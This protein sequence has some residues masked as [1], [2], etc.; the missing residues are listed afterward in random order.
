MQSI[1]PQQQGGLLLIQAET[2]VSNFQDAWKIVAARDALDFDSLTKKAIGTNAVTVPLVQNVNRDLLE[3]YA[4]SVST[5]IRQ[6]LTYLKFQTLEDPFGLR[7]QPAPPPTTGVTLDEVKALVKGEMTV[8]R[9]ATAPGSAEEALQSIRSNFPKP[10]GM[11]TSQLEAELSTDLEAVKGVSE[12]A[13]QLSYLTKGSNTSTEVDAPKINPIDFT[14][15]PKAF[16][17]IF[18][19]FEAKYKLQSPSLSAANLSPERE[20]RMGEVLKIIIFK[21]SVL[22][23][24]VAADLAARIASLS[25]AHPVNTDF[26]AFRKFFCL[27][28]TPANYDKTVWDEFTS[29]QYKGGPFQLWSNKVTHLLQSVMYPRDQ[30]AVTKAII[31]RRI[32]EVVPQQ[33]VEHFLQ[34]KFDANTEMDELAAHAATVENII[35]KGKAAHGGHSNYGALPDEEES[36]IAML[37]AQVANLTARLAAVTGDEGQT[38]SEYSDDTAYSDDPIENSLLAA[39]SHSNDLLLKEPVLNQTLAALSV[40]SAT[41]VCYNCGKMGHFKRDCS[42]TPQTKPYPSGASAISDR[43]TVSWKPKPRPLNQGPRPFG[44]RSP[45]RPPSSR[46]PWQNKSQSGRPPFRSGQQR[47]QGQYQNRRDRPMYGR[48]K[49][50]RFNALTEDELEDLLEG[51]ACPDP[52]CVMYG[53]DPQLFFL[54]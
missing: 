46:Y 35:V 52:V 29:M 19:T 20:K 41:T 2:A 15:N 38:E 36:S 12:I 43:S 45:Q 48:F 6:T 4:A 3:A 32:T 23:Q 49:A 22:T 42:E 26:G 1:M 10:G 8:L 9:Q 37:S 31:W 30:Y 28:Y 17:A 21:Q 7:T 40:A 16:Y 50:G 11:T 18:T 33:L 34:N 51:K 5:W 39:M 13:K 53:D 27:S 14:D 24:V 25:S 44:Q 54:A 47:F